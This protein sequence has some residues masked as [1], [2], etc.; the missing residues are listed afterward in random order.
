MSRPQLTQPFPRLRHKRIIAFSHLFVFTRTFFLPT[1]PLCNTSS[2]RGRGS[3]LWLLESISPR[4]LSFIFLFPRSVSLYA[5]STFKA[6]PRFLHIYRHPTSG[7]N[8]VFSPF[9]PQS[10]VPPD[11]HDFS[12]GQWWHDFS[13][14]RPL[15]PFFS[16]GPCSSRFLLLRS[17]GQPPPPRLC[18]AVN[19]PPTAFPYVE[20]TYWCLPYPRTSARSYVYSSSREGQDCALSFP[21]DTLTQS[22]L[23]SPLKGVPSLDHS[24]KFLSNFSP[25]FHLCRI[26]VH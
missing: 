11:S 10:A 25:P 5:I 7:R 23:L 18:F 16:I 24:L 17:C 21:L 3:V 14:R 15:F 1:P 22:F 8:D 19:F 26:S 4:L 9:S 20:L 13:L 2:F 6:R 12:Y